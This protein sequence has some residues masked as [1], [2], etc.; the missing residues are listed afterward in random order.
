DFGEHFTGWC[1]LRVKGR[2]G[3]RIELKF[4][5]VLTP[6][7]EVDQSNMKD[8]TSYFRSDLFILKGD[9]AGESFEPRFTFRGFRYV[10]ISGL[11]TAPTTHSIEGIFIHS[12]LEITGRLRSDPPL[13]EQIW[14]N[15]LQSQRSNFV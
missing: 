2:R 8:P 11:E 9:P 14:R 10:E 4:A 15:T 6:S 13:I 12:D 7:G 1:R 5:E 3:S